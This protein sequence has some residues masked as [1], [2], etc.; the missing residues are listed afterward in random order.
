[1]DGWET[2]RR[3]R[4]ISNVPIIM[5]SGR[6]D[7][8]DKVRGLE[9]GADDYVSKPVPPFEFVARVRA[10]LRRG[11]HPLL[12]EDI[13]R[14]DDRLA[15]HRARREAIVDGRVVRLSAIELKLLTCLLDNA[16]RISTH[17]SLLSQ[18]WGWDC[19]GQNG[20]VKVYIHQLRKKI[21]PDPRNPRYILTERGLGY[22]FQ[23]LSGS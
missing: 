4:D 5:L 10:A 14:V 8:R 3:I 16:G 9:L 11:A 19:I 2:C 13:I 17:Q 18:V 20:Y 12:V 21:E 1:M 23:A 6:T 15:I 22:R 7:E